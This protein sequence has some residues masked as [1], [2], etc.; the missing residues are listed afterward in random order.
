MFGSILV[1]EREGIAGDLSDIHHSA[2]DGVFD[3][4]AERLSGEAVAARALVG[5]RRAD[6]RLHVA[7]VPG[8]VLAAHLAELQLLQRP[9]Q[10]VHAVADLLGAVFEGGVLPRLQ[11]PELVALRHEAFRRLGP[12]EGQGER[13]LH[14]L[15]RVLLDGGGVHRQR[16]HAEGGV[17]GGAARRL[18]EVRGGGGAQA[19]VEAAEDNEKK[20]PKVRHF[21]FQSSEN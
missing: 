1:D 7:D 14:Q 13:R 15:V 18:Y 20:N 4:S 16:L 10:P 12:V 3:L 5:E 2:P 21:L 8:E 11:T 6:P 9:R 17:L 19:T